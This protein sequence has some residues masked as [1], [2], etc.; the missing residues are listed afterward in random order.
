MTAEQL[1]DALGMLPSDLITETDRLRSQPRKTVIYWRKY[2][3]IAACAVLVLGCGLFFVDKALPAM[4][5]G[6]K[7]CAI[8]E[9]ALMSYQNAAPAEMPEPD[10]AVTG[11]PANEAW[12]TL[13]DN[14][15]PY[16]VEEAEGSVRDLMAEIPD[17]P[18][19]V[20]DAFDDGV[21]RNFA[22]DLFQNAAKDGENTLIS[23][24]SVMSALA[25]TAN[26]A[27]GE[28]LTQMENAMGVPISELNS[29]LCNYMASQTDQLKLAN[30]IW[31]NSSDVLSVREDFL[32]TN[33]GY[34]H[35]DLYEAPMNMETC[36]TINDWVN[37]RTDGTIPEILDEIPADAMMYL[38]N[39]LAFEAE[40][41]EVYLE[42]SVGESTFT[43]EDGTEQTVELMHSKESMYLEDDFATGFIKPYKDGKY[44]FV[45]LLPKD[46]VSVADYVASLSGAGLQEMLQNAQDTTVY[47]AI[48]K[49]EAEYGADMAE[50][51]KKMGMTDAF[52][53]EKADFSRMGSCE[54]GNLHISRVLHKTYI[55]V[56][57]QGTKAGAATVVEILCG[58]AFIPDPKEVTLDRPFVYMLID[59]EQNLP[60]FIGTLMDTEG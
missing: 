51:L 38:V 11:A 6:T 17:E 45:A 3:A 35:A 59:C 20:L 42:T 28:T 44:A 30:S 49:F 10:A 29:Y 5:G 50:V 56:A 12:D 41:P 52:D 39:A 37:T 36:K 26:G 22:V 54:A 43:Q 23:P 9:D 1:H 4:G 8:E 27:D 40:W 57:E 16:A 46:G 15:P 55:T 33:K 7:E 19:E 47:A 53:T 31:F 2:A 25:M 24:L 14:A 34:F 32:Q 21:M 13:T 48:P 58:S 60:F 18:A